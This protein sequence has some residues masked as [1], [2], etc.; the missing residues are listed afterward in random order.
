M[1]RAMEL[2]KETNRQTNKEKHDNGHEDLKSISEQQTH[3]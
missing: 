2:K 3:I 1:D